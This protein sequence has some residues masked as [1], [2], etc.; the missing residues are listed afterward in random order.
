MIKPENHYHI[1]FKSLIKHH[2]LQTSDLLPE[3]YNQEAQSG[4]NQSMQASFI[5]QHIKKYATLNYASGLWSSE[6]DTEWCLSRHEEQISALFD[7][8]QGICELHH[9]LEARGVDLCG[10]HFSN[11]LF[12]QLFDT[13]AVD[14]L[15]RT[16]QYLSFYKVKAN[17]CFMENLWANQISTFHRASLREAKFYSE[18]SFI[19]PGINCYSTDF[20]YA[21]LSGADLRLSYLRKS[22][23]SDAIMHRTL[24]Q[25]ANLFQS[26]FAGATG[27]FSQLI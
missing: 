2:Q 27:N 17:G 21:D 23:F 12:H 5:T 9:S 20:S 25:D 19:K 26:S 13:I 15:D 18:Y 24:L 8:I 22:N 7:A 16:K 14:P 10:F 3:P 1:C 11:A 6:Y 4:S